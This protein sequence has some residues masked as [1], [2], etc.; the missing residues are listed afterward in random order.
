MRHINKSLSALSNVISALTEE[1]RTHVPYR[2]SKLTR[3]LQDALGGNSRTT[4]IAAVAPT[5][6]STEETVSTLKFADRAARV[7]TKVSVNEVV[8]DRVLLQRAHA[9][10]K[11]LRAE[12]R[13][14]VAGSGAE[15]ERLKAENA[16]PRRR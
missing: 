5:A 9:E 13:R 3:M 7:R 16:R 4:V 12:R 14:A 11:R 1:G 10:I 15:A 8:D 6:E 2:D